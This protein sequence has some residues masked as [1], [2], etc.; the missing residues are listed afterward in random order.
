MRVLTANHDPI[1]PHKILD[2]RAFAQELR[3]GYDTE[4]DRLYLRR[5]NTLLD[6]L[7]R[8]HGHGALRR[9]NLILT[10]TAPNR[11]GDFVNVAQIG[12]AILTCGCPYGNENDQSLLDRLGDVSGEGQAPFTEVFVDQFV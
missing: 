10:H 2:S 9:H 7:S 3:I 1:R 11:I 4:S 8:A 5:L 6:A 12:R